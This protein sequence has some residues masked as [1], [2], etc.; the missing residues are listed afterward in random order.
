MRTLTPLYMAL[1]AVITATATIGGTI[2]VTRGLPGQAGIC[3]IG[4][5]LIGVQIT[6]SEARY[7]HLVRVNARTAA[8]LRCLADQQ[9]TDYRDHVRISAAV[10]R[11]VRQLKLGVAKGHELETQSLRLLED[12]LTSQD[13]TGPHPTDPRRRLKSL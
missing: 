4:A 7:R 10:L 1:G 2:L 12:V 3:L 5:S 9:A 6:V 13:T 11:E 8:R